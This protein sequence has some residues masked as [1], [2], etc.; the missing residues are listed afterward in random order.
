MLTESMSIATVKSEPS[1]E[2]QAAHLFGMYDDASSLNHHM[3]LFG[4]DAET[5]Y[6]LEMASKMPSPVDHREEE[7]YDGFQGQQAQ[8]CRWR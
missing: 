8:V 6:K 1:F 2:Y 4:M 7:D 5:P 3:H